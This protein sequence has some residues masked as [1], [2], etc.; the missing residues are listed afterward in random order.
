MSSSF[1]TSLDAFTNPSPGDVVAS[2]LIGNLADSVE[3]LEATVGVT[4]SAVAG[5]HDKRIAV[6]ESAGGDGAGGGPEPALHGLKAWSFDP[7]H[8]NANARQPTSGTL[9]GTA[10]WVPRAATISNLHVMFVATGSG[11]SY[12]GLY[13]AAGTLL[14][15]SAAVSAATGGNTMK[16]YA[17]SVPQAISAGARVFAV[18]WTSNGGTSPFLMRISGGY[19][20]WDMNAN[21]SAGSYRYFTADT[22]RTTTAPATMG[23]QTATGDPIW[24]AA[25]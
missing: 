22:A 12:M 15:Q 17:L 16:T 2:A 14:S 24:F 3:A 19:G 5:S 6:L 25:S 8:T 20:A 7:V 4:G 9:Y 13:N 23:T 21:L 18:Y 11:N 1:P 10:L